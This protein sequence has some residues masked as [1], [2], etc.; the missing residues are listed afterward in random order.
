M[1][2]DADDDH[3][4]EDVGAGVGELVVA[5]EGKLDSDAEG[6]DSHDGYRADSGADGEVY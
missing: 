4:G 6:L 5:G 1:R 3:N 2:E